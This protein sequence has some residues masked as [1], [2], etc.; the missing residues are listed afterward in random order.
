MGCEVCACVGCVHVW[1]VCM[2]GVC[3][4]VGCVHVWGVCMCGV[5]ACVG[6][7]CRHAGTLKD[8]PSKCVMHCTLV[9]EGQS[10]I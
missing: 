8:T 6:V 10:A 7:V 9:G 1:G 5:C 4:C 2:C 3:A